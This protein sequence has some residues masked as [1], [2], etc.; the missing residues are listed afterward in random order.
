MAVLFSPHNQLVPTLC[1]PTY[2]HAYAY[3]NRNIHIEYLI[4]HCLR[5]TAGV[6]LCAVIEKD[7]FLCFYRATLCYAV[8][9]PYML[10]PHILLSIRL[11]VCPSSPRTDFTN[12]YISVPFLLS[13]SVLFWFIVSYFYFTVFSVCCK[14]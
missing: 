12:L 3:R 4:P 11:S 14:R 9:A 5:L 6:F 7:I 1:E 13:I 2:E 10:R 8:L